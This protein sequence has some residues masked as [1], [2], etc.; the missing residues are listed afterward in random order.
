[1]GNKLGVKLLFIRTY[2]QKIIKNLTFFCITILFEETDMHDCF[3]TVTLMDYTCHMFLFLFVRW[4]EK[5]ITNEV[6][7]NQ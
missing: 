3:A 4:K 1:M 7:R 2:A 5:V 6:L